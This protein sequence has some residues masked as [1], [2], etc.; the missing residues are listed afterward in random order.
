MMH[1]PR[2][3]PGPVLQGYFRDTSVLLR[4]Q[5]GEHAGHGR[6]QLWK[7]AGAARSALRVHEHN[8]K[9]VTRNRGDAR[10]VSGAGCLSPF[11]RRLRTVARKPHGACRKRGAC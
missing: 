3:G 7:N 8:G 10:S 1:E 2:R 5:P 4:V 6:V 9:N 11:C